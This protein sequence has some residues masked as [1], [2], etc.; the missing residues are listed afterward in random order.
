MVPPH[1][2]RRNAAERAIR[3]FKNHFIATLATTNKMFPM[4][5]WDRLL[6]QATMTLNMLWA[7]QIN[8]KLSAYEQLEGRFTYAKTPLAPPGCRVIVHKKPSVRASWA[9]HGVDAWYLGPA[10]EHYRCYRCYVPSTHGGCIADTVE[11]FPADWPMPKLSSADRIVLAA[12]E[13]VEALRHP[14]PSALFAPIS[15]QHVDNLR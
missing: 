3:T 9:P 1:M 2:H 11:F 15:T 6:P 5:L 7:S 4:H 14:T 10:M 12:K 13:L 8:P